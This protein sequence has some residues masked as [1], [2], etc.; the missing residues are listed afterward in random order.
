[1]NRRPPLLVLAV[2][3]ARRGFVPRRQERGDHLNEQIPPKK[4][5]EP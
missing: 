2:H 5:S 4:A 1:V 3:G